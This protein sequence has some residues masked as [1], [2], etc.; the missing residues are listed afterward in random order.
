[1]Y[2]VQHKDCIIYVC[3]PQQAVSTVKDSQTT[4]SPLAKPD[5]RYASGWSQCGAVHSIHF[6]K[7]FGVTW[8]ILHNPLLQ[9]F[10]RNDSASLE[11]HNMVLTWYSDVKS[12][13]ESGCQVTWQADAFRLVTLAR[14]AT[15]AIAAIS[16]QFRMQLDK[17][18]L[19]EHQIL[20]SN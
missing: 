1:M 3:T 4:P 15:S 7:S 20:H 2:I 8:C 19:L 12:S 6:N 14:C 11:S 18:Y 5:A 10:S 16:F 9:P 17:S 13:P